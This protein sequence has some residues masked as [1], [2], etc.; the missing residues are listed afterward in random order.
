VG[1]KI[2][3]DLYSGVIKKGPEKIADKTMANIATT[4][5]GFLYFNINLNKTAE[6]NSCLDILL[7]A[8]LKI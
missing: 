5:S 3:S 6:V 2:T 8:I 1:Y 7:L 4:I